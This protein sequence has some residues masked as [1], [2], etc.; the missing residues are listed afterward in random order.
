MVSNQRLKYGAVQYLSLK[1]NQLV[2][3]LR[4]SIIKG[5]SVDPLLVIPGSFND[6]LT[7]IIGEIWRWVLHPLRNVTQ[8]QPIYGRDH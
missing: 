2:L 1:V 6:L 4:R 7:M 3:A 5:V 8:A